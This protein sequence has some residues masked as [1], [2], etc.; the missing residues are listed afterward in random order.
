MMIL[1]AS[2]FHLERLNAKMNLMQFST[3]FITAG[4]RNELNTTNSDS[5][6]LATLLLIRNIQSDAEIY[7]KQKKRRTA[8]EELRR[9]SID[10]LAEHPNLCITEILDVRT[11]KMIQSSPYLLGASDYMQTNEMASKVL[12][13]VSIARYSGGCYSCGPVADAPIREL[14]S[15]PLR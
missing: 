1:V 5:K 7:G 8:E 13:Q 10:Q 9:S 4:E 15:I 11:Q 6:N 12:S 3:I 2:R 14:L